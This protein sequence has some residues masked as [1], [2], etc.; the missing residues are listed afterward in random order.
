MEPEDGLDNMFPPFEESI[1]ILCSAVLL[2]NP[3]TTAG[4]YDTIIIEDIVI[5]SGDEDIEWITVNGA[6][7]PLKNGEP[8]NKVGREIFSKETTE[9]LKK[10][11]SSYDDK[12][13]EVHDEE[14]QQLYEA[15]LQAGNTPVVKSMNDIASELKET[16]G[17]TYD[18]S[19]GEAKSAGF[20]VAI[21]GH[22]KPIRIEGMDKPQ[23]RDAL[24]DYINENMH[25]L[26]ETGNHLGGWLNPEDGVLYLDISKVTGDVKEARRNAIAANQEAFF[27]FQTMDS[28]ITIKGAAQD[29]TKQGG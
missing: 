14:R 22:E 10:R 5:D 29:R 26:A 28:V 19:T 24:R 11:L 3:L 13:S 7:I 2:D 21:E 6:R 18:I 23:V 4:L 16:G 15:S 17:F 8:Q 25:I 1:N 9:E 27:D 20:A 12:D